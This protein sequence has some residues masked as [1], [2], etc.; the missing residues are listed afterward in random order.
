MI[1]RLVALSDPVVAKA[2]KDPNILRKP[3]AEW[4][5]K[6]RAKVHCSRNE[7]V[8]LAEK[9]DALHACQLVD[10]SLID[11]AET[12]RIFSVSKDSEYDRLILN[13]TVINS[14]CYGCNSYTKTLAPTP[15]K[16]QQA[17]AHSNRKITGA[18]QRASSRADQAA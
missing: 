10:A 7:L 1:I 14:R 2:F 3:V 13:P 16:E 6:R 17:G 18:A 4:P 12:V 5:V 9:W 8:R 15:G 11:P